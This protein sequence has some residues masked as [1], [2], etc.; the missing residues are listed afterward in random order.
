[1]NRRNF[2]QTA[3]VG[4]AVLTVP[5]MTIFT[6][7]CSSS[8]ITT[9]ENDLPIIVGIAN[10]ILQVISTATGSGALAATVGAIVTQ[11]VQTL[12]TSLQALQQAI[13]AYQANTGSGLS[14]VI[15]ALT[16]A[17]TSI[18]AVIESLPAGTVS[19]VVLT[20]IVAGIGTVITILSSIQ[21]LIPGAAPTAMTARATSA[22]SNP[23]VTMPNAASLKAGFN[24]VLILQGYGSAAL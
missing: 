5:A 3:G 19:P 10:S 11:A 13:T 14:K 20:I 21:A 18:K 7:G 12:T 6:A 9:V 8:W 23:A 1:M 16:S 17:Q 15:S 2:L 4:A 22:A 24:S